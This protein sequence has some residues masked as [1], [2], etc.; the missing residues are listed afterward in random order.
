MASLQSDINP[1][2]N[3]AY[4]PGVKVSMVKIF[5]LDTLHNQATAMVRRLIAAYRSYPRAY[6]GLFQNPVNPGM[7]CSILEHSC[8]C[9]S[10]NIQVR[11]WE[12]ELALAES[13][14]LLVELFSTDGG[15]ETEADEPYKTVAKW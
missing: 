5:T 8:S 14:H 9:L 13:L 7:P 4:K 11:A 2:F 6:Y 10:A 12:K 1:L 15:K 3:G